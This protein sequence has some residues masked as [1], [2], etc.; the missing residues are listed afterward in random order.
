MQDFVDGKSQ[1]GYAIYL[2]GGPIMWVSKKHSHVGSTN[3]VKYLRDVIE[4][5]G[6]KELVSTPT[7]ILG[8]NKAATIWASVTTNFLSVCWTQCPSTAG[9]REIRPKYPEKGRE[10]LRERGFLRD[11]AKEGCPGLN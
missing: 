2:A 6:Y 8:D 3:A 5:I 10:G 11:E 4:E 1:W 9:M 7:E